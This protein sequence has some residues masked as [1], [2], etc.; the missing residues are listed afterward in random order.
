MK[1]II[2]EDEIPAQRILQ[3]YIKKIPQLELIDTFNSAVLANNTIN[4]GSIDLIFLDINLPDISGMNYLSIIKNPPN[5]IVT[6]AYPDYAVESFEKD[7]IKD[8][9]MKPFSF[10]RFLKAVNKIEN[11]IERK[12]QP[13]ED[14]IFLNLDKTHQKLYLD[15][16][17]Y[18]ESEHNYVTIHTQEKKYTF[19]DSLKNWKAKLTQNKFVQIHKSYLINTEKIDQ[20]SGNQVSIGNVKI[21]IG[22]TYKSELMRIL[23]L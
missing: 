7:M 4:N 17:L 12:T 13:T 8:Y 5:V 18:I 14:Y 9:L 21:P 2:I 10:E 6:T 1:C 20:I 22:R 23:D 16:V 19:V 15:K 11:N 3:S